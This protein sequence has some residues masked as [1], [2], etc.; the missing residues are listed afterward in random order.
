MRSY[1]QIFFLFFFPSFAK[2]LYLCAVLTKNAPV[3]ELVDTLDLGSSAVRRVS[4]SLIR[5]TKKNRPL[6]KSQRSIF[7]SIT[8]VS[9]VKEEVKME[10]NSLRS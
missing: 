7:Y 6:E 9:E 3:V 4:S 8:E 5:R 10:V 1:C 2:K